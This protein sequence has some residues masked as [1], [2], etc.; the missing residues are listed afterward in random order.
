MSYGVKGGQKEDNTCRRR[1]WKNLA[2]A[3]R[4]LH[5]HAFF[6]SSAASVSSHFFLLKFEAGIMGCGCATNIRRAW[7][8]SFDLRS[9]TLCLRPDMLEK[10]C[11]RIRC[12]LC[13]SLWRGRGLRTCDSGG[14]QLG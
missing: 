1:S 10:C 14:H 6:S 11:N 7:L 8:A 2:S 12:R 13:W 3:A 5:V 4:A 9:T